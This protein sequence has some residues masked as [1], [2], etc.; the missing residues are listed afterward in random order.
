MV[1]FDGS[2]S[3]AEN[4][5]E[6]ADAVASVATGEVTLASRDVSM[7]GVAIRKGEWVGLAAGEPVAGGTSFDEVAAAVVARL[8]HGG[9][10]ELLTLLTGEDGHPLD[11]LLEWIAEAHPSVEVDVQEGGQA[12]Y[13][14][15]LSA[16]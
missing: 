8:L 4:A 2:R 5:A 13:P 16:E 10:R 9:S 15:L 7:N 1:A 11:A 14:L 3:A 6:M 12:H